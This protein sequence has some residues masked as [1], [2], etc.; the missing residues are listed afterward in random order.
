V[1]SMT[2]NTT[3]P[4]PTPL[5]ASVTS[6]ITDFQTAEAAKMLSRRGRCVEARRPPLCTLRRKTSGCSLQR[7]T[8]PSFDSRQPRAP[9]PARGRARSRGVVMRTSRRR[10]V[11]SRMSTPMLKG[12]PQHEEHCDAPMVC[13]R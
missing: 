4:T 13:A 5:L 2:G 11:S 8:L 12:E 3:F 6:G 7:Q 1:A 10:V 9:A